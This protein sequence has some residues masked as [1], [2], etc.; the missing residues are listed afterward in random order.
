M[1]SGPYGNPNLA[2]L[3]LDAINF[4]CSA[5]GPP[6]GYCKDVFTAVWVNGAEI[7]FNE[8]SEGDV[9]ASAFNRFC[10][11]ERALDKGLKLEE[12]LKTEFVPECD[13]R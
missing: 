8:I 6:L 9:S 11:L 4:I 13:G 10:D 3:S 1:A 2:K 5:V 12:M 7:E